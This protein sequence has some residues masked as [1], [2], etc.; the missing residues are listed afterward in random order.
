MTA[1]VEWPS[2]VREGAPFRLAFVAQ[3]ALRDV[4]RFDRDELLPK[5]GL[6][7]F[8]TLDLVRVYEAIGTIKRGKKSFV[9]EGATSVM[10]FDPKTKLAR[11]ARPAD[12]PK[13]HLGAER[14]LRFASVDTWPQVEG[15][16]VGG[17]G[18][19]KVALDEPEWRAWAA[20]APKPPLAE[21]ESGLPFDF[22][23]R[24]GFL[25]VH[26]PEKSIR[27]RRWQD[28]RHKEW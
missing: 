1:E 3:I 9:P 28:A 15:T 24:S 7:S 22:F 4:A 10:C 6:L 19:G 5:S 11:R 17:P 26:A 8:F 12:L 21:N 2:V 23:G 13:S 27:A 14:K 20:S 25:F 18:R 16:I